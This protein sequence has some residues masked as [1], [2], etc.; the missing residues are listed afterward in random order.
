MLQQILLTFEQ[1]WTDKSDGRK[2]PSFVTDELHDFLDCGPCRRTV[3]KILSAMGLPTEA[4][5]RYPERPPPAEAGGEDGDWLNG[6]AADQGGMEQTV[7]RA[8]DGRI[9]TR[10]WSKT[11]GSRPE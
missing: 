11:P 1:E 3:M 5:K 8:Q 6:Q 2:L 7:P 4:P 10:E 9:R